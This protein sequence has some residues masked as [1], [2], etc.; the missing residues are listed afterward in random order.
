MRVLRFGLVVVLAC[1][2]AVWEAFLVGARPW[3]VAVP[4]SAFLAVVGNVSLGV[5]GA[6]ALGSRAGAVVPG[7]LWLAIVLGLASSRP[8]GDVV[9]P[10]TLRG[11]SFLLLGTLA[12]AGTVGVTGG[13][14]GAGLPQQIAPVPTPEALDGR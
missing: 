13:R 8:E 10:D 2:L 14:P 11:L 7:V 4:V 12:A 5:A 3:G 6:R 1:E 9:V